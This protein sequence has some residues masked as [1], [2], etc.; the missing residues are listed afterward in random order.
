[1]TKAIAL[2]VAAGSGLRVGGEIPKQ[3]LHL[4]GKPLLRHCLETF[5]A[6]PR[7]SG[8]CVVINQSYR[9]FYDA[10]AA[11]LQLLPAVNGG[12][13]RQESVRLGL[14]SLATLRPDFVLIHDAARPFLD[15]A[16]IDRSLDALAAHQ[17]ALVAV[18][19][20]DTLKRADGAFSGV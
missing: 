11:G 17:A 3:F 1:M 4:G 8:V 2:I 16:T 5:A 18:P 20:V 10:A 14:Q 9:P 13:T 6:H 7:I 15:A 12:A 19:V